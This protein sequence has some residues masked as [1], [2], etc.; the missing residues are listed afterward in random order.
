MSVNKV[1]VVSGLIIFVIPAFLFI[2]TSCS[3]EPEPVHS[4][5]HFTMMDDTLLKYNKGI[6]MTEDREIDDFV[7]RYQWNMTK[8]QTGLRFMI[9]Q[10]GNGKSAVKGKVATLKFTVKLLNGDPCYSSAADG[11]KVFVIGHG[12]V[13]SGLEEG[14]LLLKVGDHAKFILPSHL[15]FGLLGDQRKIPQNASLVYDVELVEIK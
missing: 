15:A 6:M 11:Q 13:E 4:T 1:G 5:H 8:T 14:I 2:F 9:Y 10:H 7:R 12:G 3:R